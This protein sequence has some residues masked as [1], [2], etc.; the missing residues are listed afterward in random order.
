MIEVNDRAAAFLDSEAFK[1]LPDKMRRGI[2]MM[3]WRLRHG[4]K[5]MP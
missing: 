3:E 2:E 4:K 1:R 5:W